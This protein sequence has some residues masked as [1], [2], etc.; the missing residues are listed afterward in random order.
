MRGNYWIVS[1]CVLVCYICNFKTVFFIRQSQSER[2]KKKSIENYEIT[3]LIDVQHWF[4]FISWFLNTSD[5]LLFESS[6][7]EMSVHHLHINQ[8][9]LMWTNLSK[10]KI[11]SHLFFNEILR[12]MKMHHSFSLSPT[13]SKVLWCGLNDVLCGKLLPKCN[14]MLFHAGYPAK[15]WYFIKSLNSSLCESGKND[16]VICVDPR[17]FDSYEMAPLRRVMRCAW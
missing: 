12:P 7:D 10:R 14:S 5:S 1:V 15:R 6:K 4:I 2:E 13:T 11:D 8:S 17:V 16:F 9:F 3:W